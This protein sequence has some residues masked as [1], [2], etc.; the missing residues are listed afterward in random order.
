MFS[1]PI[2]YQV[3]V[4]T[5][6]SLFIVLMEIDKPEKILYSASS[7]HTSVWS[8]NSVAGPIRAPIRVSILPRVIASKP[9]VKV[10]AKPKIQSKSK[11]KLKRDKPKLDKPKPEK[12]ALK[13]KMKSWVDSTPV[14]P[15]KSTTATVSSQLSVSDLSVKPA[16]VSKPKSLPKSSSQS[17]PKSTLYW[18]QRITKQLQKDEDKWLGTIKRPTR[19]GEQRGLSVMLPKRRAIKANQ[20][21]QLQSN[22]YMKITDQNALVEVDGLCYDVQT[23]TLPN[24]EKID[25]WSGASPCGEDR[26]EAQLKRSLNKYLLD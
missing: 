11:P 16:T 26:I 10:V 22:E 19:I 25:Q 21:T 5:L 20:P 17:K 24:G 8:S 4:V 9:S 3:A 13:A 1:L 6:F 23:M 2:R 18:Q 14:N 12:P 7:K 15:A